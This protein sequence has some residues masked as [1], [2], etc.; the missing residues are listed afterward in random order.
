MATASSNMPGESLHAQGLV[1]FI[2]KKIIVILLNEEQGTGNKTIS[3][4]KTVE[5]FLI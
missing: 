3:A 5:Q 2:Q 1:L 4:N